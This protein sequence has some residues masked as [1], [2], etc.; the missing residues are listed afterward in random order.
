MGPSEADVRLAV[1]GIEDPD[2]RRGLAELGM[3]GRVEVQKRRVAVEILVPVQG[4]PAAGELADRV[5][6]ELSAPRADGRWPEQP[7]TCV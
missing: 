6:A 4:W 2:L 7:L 5:R 1:S 3:V